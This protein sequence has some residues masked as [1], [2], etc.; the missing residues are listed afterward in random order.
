[1]GCFI[2]VEMLLAIV[3]IYTRYIRLLYEF[4]VAPRRTVLWPFILSESPMLFCFE[5]RGMS[6]AVKAFAYDSKASHNRAVKMRQSCA[7]AIL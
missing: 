2:T 5:R 4:H 6:D 1:M 7:Y 3:L